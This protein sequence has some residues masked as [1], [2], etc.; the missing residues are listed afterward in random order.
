M[1]GWYLTPPKVWFAAFGLYYGGCYLLAAT[2]DAQLGNY[3]ALA[4]AFV[5]LFVSPQAHAIGAN[6]QSWF[7]SW[8]NK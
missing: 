1:S 2:V 5:A 8:F 3:L 7:D 6:A 4:G